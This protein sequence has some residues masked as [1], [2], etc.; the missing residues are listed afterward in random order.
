MIEEEISKL[1]PILEDLVSSVESIQVEKKIIL[2]Q[3]YGKTFFIPH[4]NY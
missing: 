1:N 2:C 4:A 3:F